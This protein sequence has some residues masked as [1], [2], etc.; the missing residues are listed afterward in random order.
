MEI[1]EFIEGWKKKVMIDKKGK[2][3]MEERD[4]IIFEKGIM[5][6]V[7]V[8]VIIEKILLEWKYREKNEKED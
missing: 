4:I 5:M 3:G 7:V 2:V 8:K 1:Y 6:I